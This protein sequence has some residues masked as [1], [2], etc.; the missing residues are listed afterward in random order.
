MSFSHS[1]SPPADSPSISQL[2]PS[3]YTSGRKQNMHVLITSRVSTQSTQ[4]TP[5]KKQPRGT[6]MQ[7]MHA[8]CRRIYRGTSTK[9]EM[10]IPT[11]GDC[12]P[13]KHGQPKQREVLEGRRWSG[14][15]NL[16]SVEKHCAPKR[17]GGKW[18]APL[19]STKQNLI[20]VALRRNSGLAPF[21]TNLWLI[22]IHGFLPACLSVRHRRAAVRFLRN[23][24]RCCLSCC[25]RC[26][27]WWR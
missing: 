10:T 11:V 25:C 3:I 14:K 18:S 17:T 26:W 27:W 6:H 2:M 19:E 9:P 8:I 22:Y 12:K 15:I 24:L 20:W 4:Q 16:H 1:P 21:C 23:E 5:T 13:V 7:M